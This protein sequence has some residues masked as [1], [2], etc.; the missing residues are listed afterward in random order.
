MNTRI[1]VPTDSLIFS[2]DEAITATLQKIADVAGSPKEKYI[3]VKGSGEATIVRTRWLASR[4]PGWMAWYILG[5]PD[6]RFHTFVG[7]L[8]V[9]SA[10]LKP[11][12][13]FPGELDFLLCTVHNRRVLR[14]FKD[15]HETLMSALCLCGIYEIRERKCPGYDTKDEWDNK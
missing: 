15:F 3:V 4:L 12:Q 9:F 11:I 5:C 7:Y 1:S 6:D 8:K 14:T 2:L 10:N 13:S